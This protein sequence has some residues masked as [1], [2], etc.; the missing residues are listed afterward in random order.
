M[1]FKKWKSLSE[2]IGAEKKAG[3]GSP[4]AC[5]LDPPPLTAQWSRGKRRLAAVTVERVLR[6]PWLRP[7]TEK[8]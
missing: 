8:E 7:L 3:T 6:P 4:L 5:S 1:R 2:S